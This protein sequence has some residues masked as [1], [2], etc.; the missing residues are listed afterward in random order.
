MH[1]HPHLPKLRIRLLRGEG[2]AIGTI[3]TSRRPGAGGPGAGRHKQ[4]AAQHQGNHK[5]FENSYIHLQVP[6][7]FARVLQDFLKRIFATKIISAGWFVN[8]RLKRTQ[9]RRWPAGPERELLIALL[10]RNVTKVS[11]SLKK[12]RWVPY[13]LPSPAVIAGP[14]EIIALICISSNGICGEYDFR[15]L[16]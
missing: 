1:I 12:L 15:Y 5:C 7:Y 6:S 16:S 11:I 10:P 9:A 2:G 3:G 4:Q 14:A 8:L 13:S